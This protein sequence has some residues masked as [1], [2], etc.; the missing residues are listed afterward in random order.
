M[1]SHPRD[2]PRARVLH[3][4]SALEKQRA[5]GKPDARCTRGLVCKLCKRKRTRAYRSSGGNPTFPAQW[6]YSLSR[7]L[8]GD[9]TWDCHR[10]RRRLNRRLDASLEASG[11]HAFA[12]RLSAVRLTAPQRPPHPRPASM[13]LANAPLGGT[14]WQIIRLICTSEKQKY[15][16]KRGWT[17][18]NQNTTDLP[19]VG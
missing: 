15:F 8:P 3:E 5:Q 12:V 9:Q 11:P 4:S 10:H 1:T 17:R 18:H 13:T 16:C 19:V 2:A 7:A 14:G 6:F